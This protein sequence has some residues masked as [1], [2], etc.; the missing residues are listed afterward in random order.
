VAAWPP[1]VAPHPSN[2]LRGNGVRC[3]RTRFVSRCGVLRNAQNSILKPHSG[4]R[5]LR[6]REGAVYPSTEFCAAKLH[7]QTAQR[8]ETPSGEGRRCVS[9]RGVCVAN[10]RSQIRRICVPLT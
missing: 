3:R 1:A 9:K 8:F 4:L 7:S 6:G 10:S 2:P 5:P